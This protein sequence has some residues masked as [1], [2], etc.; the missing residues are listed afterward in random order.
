MR[1]RK[2]PWLPRLT[3]VYRSVNRGPSSSQSEL[4]HQVLY[5]GTRCWMVVLVQNGK[6]CL[7]NRQ[8]T[9]VSINKEV[10]NN[11]QNSLLKLFNSKW[12][13]N[14]QSVRY[15]LFSWVWFFW[16][17]DGVQ[18]WCGFGWQPL[19]SF[20]SPDTGSLTTLWMTQFRSLLPQVKGVSGPRFTVR[21][22]WP[23]V[24]KGHE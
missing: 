4:G 3:W 18:I 23:Y 20:T 2:P 19:T 24:K 1:G 16:I 21:L 17:R 8:G 12:S 15:R 13:V 11:G 7:L 6:S 5:S 22:G 14:P 9:N 10:G